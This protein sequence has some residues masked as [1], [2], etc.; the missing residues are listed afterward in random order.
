MGQQVIYRELS[1]WARFLALAWDFSI[2]SSMTG[3][4]QHDDHAQRYIQKLMCLRFGSMRKKQKY[5]LKGGVALNEYRVKDDLREYFTS[6]R[7]HVDKNPLGTL[8]MFDATEYSGI[9]PIHF[10]RMLLMKELG[11]RAPYEFGLVLCRAEWSSI[12]I[13]YQ[14]KSGL[15]LR[16]LNVTMRGG[17]R[18]VLPYRIEVPTDIVDDA[19]EKISSWRSDRPQKEKVLIHA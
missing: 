6:M 3:K 4:R 2:A 16:L 14:W 9:V 18:G 10:L 12:D 1:S 7:I 11:F 15:D 8:V 5:D 17:D 13:P 19:M